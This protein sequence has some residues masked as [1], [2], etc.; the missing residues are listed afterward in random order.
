MYTLHHHVE[1]SYYSVNGLEKKIEE[2]RKKMYDS[3]L[4]E[5]DYD[6]VLRFSQELDRLLNK[7][8]ELKSPQVNR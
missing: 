8:T 2:T 5:Q 3:Y 6:Q 7:W 1:E 4:S